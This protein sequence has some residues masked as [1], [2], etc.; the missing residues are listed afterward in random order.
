MSVLGAVPCE[1]MQRFAVRGIGRS[2]SRRHIKRVE[3]AA[4][5]ATGKG[6]GAQRGSKGTKE[7]HGGERRPRASYQ[8]L[9]TARASMVSRRRAHCRLPH[10]FNGSAASLCIGEGRAEGGPECWDGESLTWIRDEAVIRRLGA[11]WG[12]I[13]RGRHG[14]DRVEILSKAQSEAE[15]R[16]VPGEARRE[17]RDAAKLLRVALKGKAW[18]WRMSNGTR[19]RAGDEEEDG[20]GGGPS[21]HFPFFATKQRP[22]SNRKNATFHLLGS[23]CHLYRVPRGGRLDEGEGASV[24]RVCMRQVEP[25]KH[26]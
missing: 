10:G 4:R 22:G 8:W 24:S 19:M 3:L 14:D 23:A 7:Q 12:R 1:A 16:S 5:W 26:R 17:H 13:W 11:S 9:R 15:G 21:D 6:Y 25:I 2:N 20:R 18:L